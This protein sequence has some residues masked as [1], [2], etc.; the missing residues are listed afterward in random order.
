MGFDDADH[1][2]LAAAVAANPFAQHAVGLTYA[3]RIAEKQFKNAL[4]LIWRNFF[5]PLLWTLL[6][7]IILIR[8]FRFVEKARSRYGN[9]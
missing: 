3:G 2:V 4:F 9:R 8:V 5:Q 7:A 6:H 1:D